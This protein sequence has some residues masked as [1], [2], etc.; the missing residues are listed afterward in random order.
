M[1]PHRVGIIGAHCS[2]LKSLLST[3]EEKKEEVEQEETQGRKSSDLRLPPPGSPQ[4]RLSTQS[5]VL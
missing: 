5:T 1:F 4:N 2:E 3:S